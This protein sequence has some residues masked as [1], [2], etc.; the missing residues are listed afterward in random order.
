MTPVKV[1]KH[2]QTE[3]LQLQNEITYLTSRCAVIS[4][5][6]II[7]WTWSLCFKYSIKIVII[8]SQKDAIYL[9]IYT[10]R[11]LWKILINLFLKYKTESLV[12][13]DCY[14][15][16]KIWGVTVNMHT[17]QIMQ[18]ELIQCHSNWQWEIH[19]KDYK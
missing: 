17:V 19:P 3:F 11:F 18:E 6:K 13:P 9:N 10:P 7:S 5:I 8:M 15:N 16:K 14:K 4:H 1:L 2:Y 12:S